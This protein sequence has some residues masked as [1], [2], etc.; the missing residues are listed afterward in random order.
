MQL[1]TLNPELTLF[2]QAD[3]I[4]QTDYTVFVH[5][6][7]SQ[8]NLVAQADSPPAAGT[9]P[10]SLWDSGEIIKD[11]RLLPALSPGDYT[12]SVGLYRPDTFERLPVA[13]QPDGVV[14]LTSFKI[15]AQ[16]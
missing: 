3:T 16:N 1:G 6:L 11:Q 9:Y 8:G 10:T 15:P 5:I 14:T 2:W 13:N 7:N 4:P 12:L